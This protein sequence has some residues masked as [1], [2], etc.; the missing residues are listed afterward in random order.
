[1]Q[2]QSTLHFACLPLDNAT[3]LPPPI[4]PEIRWYV[5]S[6]ME[7]FAWRRRQV[8][9]AMLWAKRRDLEFAVYKLQGI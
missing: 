2:Q 5:A 1:M 6:T 4:H 8:H 7:A 3:S 9:N